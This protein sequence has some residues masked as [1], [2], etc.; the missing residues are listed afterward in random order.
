MERCLYINKKKDTE[1]NLVEY[2]DI[3][4]IKQILYDPE[5]KVFFIL[6]NR[7]NERLGIF[8]LKIDE[9]DPKKGNFLVNWFTQLDISN[10]SMDILRDP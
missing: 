1:F 9:N 2:Y 4:N 10:T 6:S 7:F 3:Q 5:E 8:V